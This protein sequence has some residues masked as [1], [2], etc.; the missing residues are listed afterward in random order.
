MRSNPPGG[1]RQHPPARLPVPPRTAQ[2]C[3]P[4]RR[5]RRP[6]QS[7]CSGTWTFLAAH[8]PRSPGPLHRGTRHRQRLRL[9]CVHPHLQNPPQPRATSARSQRA[10][11]LRRH[12]NRSDGSRLRRPVRQRL[13]ATGHHLLR[14]CLPAGAAWP[15]AQSRPVRKYSKWPRTRQPPPR[16]RATRHPAMR[17]ATADRHFRQRHR[18]PRP[19]RYRPT[20]RLQAS[21][22]SRS[23][24]GGRRGP[25][26]SPAHGRWIRPL[27][28]RLAHRPSALQF[29]SGRRAG[30]SV[31]TYPARWIPR[32]C[33]KPYR[34]PGR[35]W[36]D[37]RR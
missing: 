33:R 20:S 21:S 10:R 30:K 36:R 11:P 27:P 2:R 26:Q 25:G 18:G 31:R 32:Q 5:R 29:C 17:L 13:S 23:P 28:I 7:R 15:Q 6:E 12:R 34:L 16:R 8:H 24:S 3:R 35:G 4:R 22:R 1:H 9:S 14:P 37:T 19:L